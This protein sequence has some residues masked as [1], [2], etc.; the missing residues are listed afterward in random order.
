MSVHSRLS[1]PG[2]LV[3]VPLGHFKHVDVWSKK[4]L[5]VVI[6][7]TMYVHYITIHS[8]V[9]LTYTFFTM[10]QIKIGQQLYLGPLQKIIIHI[11][12]IDI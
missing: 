4:N 6:I 5:L 9:I 3:N 7:Y 1:K 11:R 10:H 8:A 2:V 12:Q